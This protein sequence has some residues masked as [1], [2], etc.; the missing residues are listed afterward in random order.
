[1]QA[2]AWPDEDTRGGFVGGGWGIHYQ[3][4]VIGTKMAELMANCD[5][6]LCSGGGPL[7]IFFPYGRNEEINLI[8][9]T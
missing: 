4:E 5:G 9:N 6:A 8:L 7:R 3:D 1:M 2:P